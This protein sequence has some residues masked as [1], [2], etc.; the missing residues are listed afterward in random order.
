M[1]VEV[2]AVDG[3][4]RFQPIQDLAGDALE[5]LLLDMCGRARRAPE[6]RRQ[7]PAGLARLSD[8]A[9]GADIGVAHRLDHG[10]ARNE[11]R[12]A[13]AALEGVIAGLGGREGVGLMQEACDGN[14]GNRRAH[15]DANS[16]MW[17]VGGK[18]RKLGKSQWRPGAASNRARV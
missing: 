4:S 6:E 11:G 15:A 13:A 14:T 2:Y 8:E 5:R 3:Q 7:R 9:E 17:V 16:G 1:Q 10:L 18:G 12:P